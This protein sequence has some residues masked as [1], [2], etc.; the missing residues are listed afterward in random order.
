MGGDDDD[1]PPIIVNNGSIIFN[2][3]DPLDPFKYW[4]KWRPTRSDDARF[5]NAWSPD[6][7]PD[8]EHAKSVESFKVVI[9]GVPGLTSP[10]DAQLKGGTVTI[11]FTPDGSSAVQFRV[12]RHH[13]SRFLFA[14]K[15]EPAITPLG[16]ANL[17]PGP[18]TPG[19]PTLT[20][21]GLGAI[22]KVT[23]GA[24]ACSIPNPNAVKATLRV[25]I[26]PSSVDVR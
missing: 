16:G 22:T 4:E 10:C 3:G 20:Y 12:D 21:G 2:G 25:Y 26:K 7:G 13:V 23:V 17:T 1:R 24:T 5:K 8:H 9:V 11:E 6:P 19:P 18:Q 15:Y 14:V